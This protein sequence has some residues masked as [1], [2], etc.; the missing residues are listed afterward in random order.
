MSSEQNLNQLPHR[1][2]EILSHY[3]ACVH[4]VAFSVRGIS[5]FPCARFQL[6]PVNKSKV[7]IC[8]Q[9]RL[10]VVLLPAPL[11]NNN[12]SLASDSGTLVVL[13]TRGQKFK[14]PDF[15]RFC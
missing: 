15:E 8:R 6:L 2:I 10:A 4:A 11:C 13:S 14:L 12:A 1:I 9:R 5:F 7:S 3:W